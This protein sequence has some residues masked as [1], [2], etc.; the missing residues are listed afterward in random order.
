MNTRT[1]RVTWE[2]WRDDEAR[3]LVIVPPT[4]GKQTMLGRQPIPE[5]SSPAHRNLSL[6]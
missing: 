2:M 6:G 5:S 4:N 3:M 1:R